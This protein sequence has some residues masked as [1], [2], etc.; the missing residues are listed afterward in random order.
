MPFAEEFRDPYEL[1]IKPACVEAGAE[2]TRVDEQ[3]FLENILER[4]YGQIAKADVIVAEMT[5]R[6]PN[7][8]YEVGY[9]HGLGKSVILVTSTAADIPFDLLHYPHVVYEGQIRTLKKELEKK[10]RWCI[11]NPELLKSHNAFRATGIDP[12]HIGEQISSY[13]IANGYT[14]ISFERLTKLMGFTEDQMRKVI[15]ESPNKFRYS[16]L[17]GNKPGIAL[18]KES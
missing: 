6:T 11:E 17:T 5:G 10:I 1:A 9:A 7:V 2:C 3:L 16:L 15:R 4:I 14:R 12:D 13:L 18:I 8:F